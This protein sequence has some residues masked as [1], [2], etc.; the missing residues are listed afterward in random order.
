[1]KLLSLPLSLSNRSFLLSKWMMCG[2]KSLSALTSLSLSF[3][4][5]IAQSNYFLS[6]FPSLWFIPKQLCV[7]LNNSPICIIYQR[8]HFIKFNKTS[9]QNSL[10]ARYLRAFH[11]IMPVVTSATT[12]WP[13]VS[14]QA[15]TATTTAAATT[16][17]SINHKTDRQV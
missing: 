9:S 3:S 10:V 13:S 8:K 4:L 15:I 6:L 1:M 5:S 12:A 11:S 17:S 16:L 14:Y 7:I 2:C